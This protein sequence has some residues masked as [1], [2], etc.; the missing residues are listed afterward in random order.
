MG[1]IETGQYKVK[2]TLRLSDIKKTIANWDDRMSHTEFVIRVKNLNMPNVMKGIKC[3]DC[4]CENG[5]LAKICKNCY[6]EL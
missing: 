3:W 6:T 5:K 2:Q 4:G 1:I